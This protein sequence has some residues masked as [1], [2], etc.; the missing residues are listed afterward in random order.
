MSLPAHPS[1]F[2]ACHIICRLLLCLAALLTPALAQSGPLPADSTQRAPASAASLLLR[3]GTNEFG[4]W[5]GYSPFSFVL[6]GTSKDR[7]LFLLNL[8]YARTLLAGRSVTLK[9]TAEIVPVA[10]EI[11]PT[12]KFIVDGKLLINPGGAIYGVG[13]TPIGVQANFGPKRIQPF[14]NG[15]LGFLHFNQQVPILK[16]AQFNY[17]ISIGFG[18]QVFLRPGRS[19]SFGWKYHHLSNDDQA[20]LN[21]GIDSGVFFVGFSVFRAKHE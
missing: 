9:Y 19:L 10:F 20:H 14:M 13:A 3:R 12:Q 18:A 1:T 15:S 16:S 4:L 7:Q 2:P 11:Q 21:P 6:K 17:T 5:S 8:Q